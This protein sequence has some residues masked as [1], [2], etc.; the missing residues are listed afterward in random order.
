MNS[1]D[2]DKTVF[3]PDSSFCFFMYC[4]VHHPLAV[5]SALPSSLYMLLRHI[6]GKADTKALKQCAFS[7]LKRLGNVDGDVE[8][9]WKK[10]RH[11]IG[12]WYLK[13]KK[14]DDIIISASPEFLLK[15]A[16]DELGVRLIA[17]RMDKHS[18][19]IE[20]RNCH[21]S[22]KVSRLRE[23]CPDA[24]VDEFYSDSLSDS[25]MAD[26]A[27]KAFI[28]KKGKISPWPDK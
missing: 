22:E 27:E 14:N 17:T 1:Y 25:P 24:A 8:K 19:K 15:P 28:V 13:Q 12:N 7:Y 2:F 3:Y 5:I 16:A 26:I 11:R 23:F 21:D 6:S 9:F 18:G 10:N 20:G 4:L